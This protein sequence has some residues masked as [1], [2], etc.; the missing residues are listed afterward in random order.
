MGFLQARLIIFR[1]LA[2]VLLLEL[3]IFLLSTL[4]FCLLA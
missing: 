4:S 1:F 2:R 3:H